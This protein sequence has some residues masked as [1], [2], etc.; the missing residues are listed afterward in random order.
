MGSSGAGL[1][2]MFPVETRRSEL[3]LPALTSHRWRLLPRSGKFCVQRFSSHRAVPRVSW[4]MA[5]GCQP[6]AHPE[7]E[8]IVPSILKKELGGA[9][10][11]GKKSKWARLCYLAYLFW[12][13][14]APTDTTFYCLLALQ[15][16]SSESY[17]ICSFFKY[18]TMANFLVVFSKRNYQE[19][20][21]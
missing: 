13:T 21:T 18:W 9:S 5:K 4:L 1:S 3:Y 12:G 14:A 8:G 15:R 17:T 19:W 2:E 10:Y 6:A 7:A 16:L 20:E 11:I